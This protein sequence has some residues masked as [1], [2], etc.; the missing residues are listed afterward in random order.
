MTKISYN[1][2]GYLYCSITDNPANH[3]WIFPTADECLETI[4]SEIRIE[5]EYRGYEEEQTTQ[6]LEHYRNKIKNYKGKL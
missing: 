4:E 3:A 1:G 6:V 5:C 2:A